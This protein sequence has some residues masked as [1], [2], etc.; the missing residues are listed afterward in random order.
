LGDYAVFD[1]KY[2]EFGEDKVKAKALDDR[3]GCA[4]LVELIKQEYDYDIYT[5]F[6]VQ[7]GGRAAGS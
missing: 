4:M 7:E 6:S 1:S 5:C 3:A 2:V